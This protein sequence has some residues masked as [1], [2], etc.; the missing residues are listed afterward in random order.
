MTLK[1]LYITPFLILIGSS[2]ASFSQQQP[3]NNDV[4]DLFR[5]TATNEYGYKDSKGN[6]AIP[7]GKYGRCYTE[8]FRTYAIVEDPQKGL[9]A[10]DR[11]EHILYQVFI[12][13]NGLDDSSDG[14]FR[15]LV[16]N[17]IGYADYSTGKIVI[18]PQFVCA[19]PFE[20]GI[21]KVS[22]DCQKRSDGEHSTWLSNDWYYINKAGKKVNPPRIKNSNNML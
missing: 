7:P 4:L 16:K 1:K 6:I 8:A 13:D 17:R 5:D 19:W 20:H 10:I 9:V 21:A 18:Y 14:L 22:I 12:F 3:K 2:L 11:Q 15:I